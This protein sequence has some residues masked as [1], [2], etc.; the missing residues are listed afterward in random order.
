[1]FGVGARPGFLS[2]LPIFKKHQDS[3]DTLSD[4]T[5]MYDA[6]LLWPEHGRGRDSS[7]G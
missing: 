6:C 3:A 4:V 2:G 7:E 1:M 5:V